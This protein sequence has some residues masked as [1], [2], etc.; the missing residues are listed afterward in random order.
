MSEMISTLH[1]RL[2]G[3]TW[4]NQHQHLLGAFLILILAIV[5]VAVATWMLDVVDTAPTAP[6]ATADAVPE[7]PSR[8]LPREWRWAPKS[9]EV[10]HMYREGAEPR[11]TRKWIR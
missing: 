7:F 4:S 1:P 10:E 8:E 6:A 9:V 5:G 2:S 3:S 11:P